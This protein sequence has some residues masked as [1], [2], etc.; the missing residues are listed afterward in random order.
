[1]IVVSNSESERILYSMS[2]W[3]STPLHTQPNVISAFKPLGGSIKRPGSSVKDGAMLRVP[4]LVNKYTQ[5][6]KKTIF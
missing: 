4:Q 1:M 5:I 2:L 6:N 3:H